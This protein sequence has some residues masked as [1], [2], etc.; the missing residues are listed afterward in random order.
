MSAR[1][2]HTT[3]RGASLERLRRNICAFEVSIKLIAVVEA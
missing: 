1:S 3:G 2:N